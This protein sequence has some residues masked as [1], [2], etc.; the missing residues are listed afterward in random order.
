MSSYIG[1]H[2]ELYDLFYATKDYE[3]E[4]SFVDNA[5]KEHGKSNGVSLLEL[6]CGT[7]NHAF[8]L[9]KAGYRICAIDYSPSMIARARK[10]AALSN[11]SIR[12]DVQDMIELSCPN[13]RFQTV[14]CLFDSIGYVLT[15]KN[16]KEVFK[17]V[18]NVLDEG[19]L[20]IFE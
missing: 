8:Q 14:I 16:I 7:G 4:S 11:S 5:I 18:N 1:E 19:G 13:E 6:A 15:N 9:E 2:A 12:F 10:K 17:R 20:F 3:Y